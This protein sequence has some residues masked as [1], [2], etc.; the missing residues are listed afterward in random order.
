MS[1]YTVFLNENGMKSS[2][3]AVNTAFHDQA[4]GAVFWALDN[5]GQ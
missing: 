1:D 5:R 2:C 3:T 4:G